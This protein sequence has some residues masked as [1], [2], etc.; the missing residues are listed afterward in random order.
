[1]IARAD[2]HD[3]TWIKPQSCKR[4]RRSGITGCRLH[5]YQTFFQSGQLCLDM[6]YMAR[7]GHNH[8]S[9]ESVRRPGAVD[10]RFE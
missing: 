1:M 4:N 3:S 8:W 2:K 5:N 9:R 6:F 7:T 10:R